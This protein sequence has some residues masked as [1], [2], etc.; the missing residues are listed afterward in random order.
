MSKDLN[1]QN[2]DLSVNQIV[3]FVNAAKKGVPDSMTLFELVVRCFNDSR[4]FDSWF[5]HLDVMN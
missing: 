3:N 5:N 4:M 2:K 1:C